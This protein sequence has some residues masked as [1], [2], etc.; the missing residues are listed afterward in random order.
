[1]G[2][3]SY[4]LHDFSPAEQETIQSTLER[5]I[6]AVLAFISEDLVTAMNRYNSSGGSRGA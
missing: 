4:V 2:A 3:A 6:E 1:M 5:A